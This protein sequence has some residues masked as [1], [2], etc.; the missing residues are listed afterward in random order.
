MTNCNTFIVNNS[1]E[2]DNILEYVLNMAFILQTLF[3]SI[4]LRFCQERRHFLS[5]NLQNDLDLL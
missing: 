5:G 2:V 1:Q 3:Q 4:P